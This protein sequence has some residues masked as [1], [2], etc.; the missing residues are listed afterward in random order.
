MEDSLYRDG[1]FHIVVLYI[2]VPLYKGTSISG[3]PTQGY[4]RVRVSLYRCLLYEELPIW[5]I[6]V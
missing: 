6:L 5:G 1:L 4:P 3:T 2:G